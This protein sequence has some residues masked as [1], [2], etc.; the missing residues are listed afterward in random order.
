MT[1][2]EW[3]NLWF[4]CSLEASSTIYF[5]FKEYGKHS[6]I[7]FHLLCSTKSYRF[8]TTFIFSAIPFVF[9]GVF[10]MIAQVR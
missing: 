2:Y 7:N 5:N 8:E 9:E 1:W 10:T 4:L 3:T 6:L